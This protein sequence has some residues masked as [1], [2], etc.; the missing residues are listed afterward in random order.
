MIQIPTNARQRLAHAEAHRLRRAA[1]ANLFRAL[2]WKG[3][4]Q[5]GTGR[6]AQVLPLSGEVLRPVC[7]NG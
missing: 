2:K 1:F 5:D 7:G 6:K 3:R 4:P